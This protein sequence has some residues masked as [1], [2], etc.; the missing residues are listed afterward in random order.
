MCVFLL[1]RTVCVNVYCVCMLSVLELLIAYELY[2]HKTC[3]DYIISN[4][5]LSTH[6]CTG[7]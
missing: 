3:N 1:I 2:N 4:C 7:V 5:I 6:S